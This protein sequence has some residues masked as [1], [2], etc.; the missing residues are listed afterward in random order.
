MKIR[1][2]PIDEVI[3]FT[4]IKSGEKD[5]I[6][7]NTNMAEV[8]FVIQEL[9]DLLKAKS[10]KSVGIITPHT[11]QQRLFVEEIN[12][13]S[14]KDHL[15]E[16]LKLKIMTFDTCQGEERDTIFYSMVA[17]Q[18]SDKLWGI[19]IKDLSKVDI[20]EDG[21][22][23]AQRLNVGLSR[24]RE[25]IHFVISKPL[26]EFSGS[27]GEALR[28][29]K[30]ELE[31]AKK[32]KDAKSTDPRSAM[33]PVVL[34]WFYQTELW[35]SQGK[36]LDLIPS[37]EIGKYLK[38]LDSNYTHP[39]YKVDFLLVYRNSEGIQRKIIIEYDGFYEH[40]FGNSLVN[41]QNYRDYMSEADLYREK[42]LE[43]YGYA[44]VRIN[45][46]NVGK[47]PVKVLN[48]R[49]LKAIFPENVKKSF[50]STLQE[51]VQGLQT[52]DVKECAKCQELKPLKE[53]K[54][55]NLQSGLGRIC[56]ACKKARTP[57]GGQFSAK[58]IKSSSKLCPLCG[59]AMYYRSGRN[60]WFY[61]CVKYPYCKGTRSR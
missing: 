48:D 2:V 20:E 41:S 32:E 4:E 60:G 44:F 50:I 33:E 18:H 61:G 14:E 1:G 31:L 29:Y 30:A 57:S 6:Y 16:S 55:P 43:S 19:F 3:K 36:F 42:V 24:G 9:L 34:N 39:M 38:Q 45:K 27:I 51:T 17:N 22:V 13:L 54:D 23:K 35:K 12:K 52:G 46:F 21:Q 53:F 10:T 26:E 25:T 47:E 49:L 58:K 37:F 7:Q 59:S 5:E 28:H 15:Y 8:K 40:F 56:L 11:N